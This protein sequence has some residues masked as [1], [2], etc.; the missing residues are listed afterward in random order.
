ML[1]GVDNVGRGCFGHWAVVWKTF[2]NVSGA[3][4][5]SASDTDATAAVVLTCR[6]YIPALMPWAAQ[7]RRWLGFSWIRI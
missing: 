1:D 2:D 5:C 4:G 3:F 6:A 7:V